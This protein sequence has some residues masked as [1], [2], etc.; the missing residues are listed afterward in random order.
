[1]TRDL[2]SWR[3]E[4]ARRVP[5]VDGAL[6]HL[7]AGLLASDLTPVDLLLNVAD[8]L[9]ED[10]AEL[11]FL[12]LPRAAADLAVIRSMIAGE[13]AARPARIQ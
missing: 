7:L 1:M 2:K 5:S 13:A 10:E 9:R 3:D 12:D 8:G 4:F 11:T 6:V